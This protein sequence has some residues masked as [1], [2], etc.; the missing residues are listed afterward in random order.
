[1]NNENLKRLEQSDISILINIGQD[2][3][4]AGKWP[5]YIQRIAICLIN[6]RFMW[7]CKNIYELLK[8]SNNKL[9][10]FFWRNHTL[11]VTL[12]IISSNFIDENATCTIIFLK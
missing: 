4:L 5:L 9:N 7:Q 10:I 11:V 12:A 8:I 6:T 1:M 3:E 2:D